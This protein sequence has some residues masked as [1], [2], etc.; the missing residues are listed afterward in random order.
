MRWSIKQH[1]GGDGLREWSWSKSFPAAPDTQPLL[2]LH[3]SLPGPSATFCKSR[4][5]PHAEPGSPPFIAATAPVLSPPRV[6]HTP[7][8]MW[9]WMGEHRAPWKRMTSFSHTGFSPD[10]VV[11]LS[12][13]T[14]LSTRLLTSVVLKLGCA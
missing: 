14:I 6:A 9:T 12:I 3:S 10:T 4:N 5:A 8:S 7:G 1:V 2:C 11:I 13:S